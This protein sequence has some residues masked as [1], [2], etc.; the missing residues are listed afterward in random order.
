MNQRK[1]RLRSRSSLEFFKSPGGVMFR[2]PRFAEVEMKLRSIFTNCDHLVE[3][4]LLG[5]G[6]V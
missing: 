4:T 2:K 1:I 6:V 3:C 5:Q